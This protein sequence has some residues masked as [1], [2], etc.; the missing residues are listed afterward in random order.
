MVTI[1]SR[2][3]RSSACTDC[4]LATGPPVP[5]DE[6]EDADAEEEIWHRSTCRRARANKSLMWVLRGFRSR[7]TCLHLSATCILS[8]STVPCNTLRALSSFY[9][10]RL[11]G[12]IIVQEKDGKSR[13]E[14]INILQEV[15]QLDSLLVRKIRH[16]CSIINTKEVLNCEGIPR[17]DTL[18]VLF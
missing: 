10:N 6:R 7:C 2:I 17:K 3:E 12:S 8:S 18:D 1:R 14:D 9:I 11:L 15:S 4:T 5:R 13:I 16:S